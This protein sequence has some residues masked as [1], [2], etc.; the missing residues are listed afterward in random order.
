[1]NNNLKKKTYFLL[2]HTTIDICMH[3]YT[4][5]TTLQ[6]MTPI[7]IVLANE[8]LKVLDSNKFYKKKKRKIERRVGL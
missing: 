3:S 4:D 2:H 7:H 1:M 5:D 6:F 8:V